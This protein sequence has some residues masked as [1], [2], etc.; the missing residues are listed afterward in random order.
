MV[1]M[2]NVHE[3]TFDATPDRLA[4]LIADFDAVWPTQIEPAPRLDGDVWRV[5]PMRWQE[6]DRPGAVRAFRIVSPPG[7]RGEHWF[8]LEPVEGGTRVRHTVDG[9]ASGPF[10]AVWRDR[11]E[12]VH[13][14][15]LEAILDN[16]GRLAAR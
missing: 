9:E 15:I 13:D 1:R 7:M 11:I 16:I 6:I 5:P 4:P 10:E 14:L 2:H 12:P 8:E 3:R